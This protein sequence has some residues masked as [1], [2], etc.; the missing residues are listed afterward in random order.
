M[1]GSTISHYRI[2]EKI[3]EGGMGVVYKA[4]DTRLR[5]LVALKFL[6]E[7]LAGIPD[8]VA[9]F[10]REARHA[11]ALNHSHICTIY[12][13]AE[14]QG[15]HFIAMELLEGET[16]R[17]R[18]S[19]RTL[20][21]NE[22]IKMAIQ[23]ADAL[24]AAHD[25]G[26]I[27]QDLKPSNLFVTARGDV[28]ILD[29]GIAKWRPPASAE[30]ATLTRTSEPGTVA[31]TVRY[32]SPEQALG[33][34]AD[35]RSDLFSLG[36]VFYEMAT[37]RL[38]FNGAT[39]NEI[40][41]QIIHHQP[42]AIG[43]FNHDVPAELEAIIRKCLEKEPDRRYQAAR[44][45]LVDLRNLHRDRDTG[46]AGR[47]AKVT[48][49]AVLPLANMSGDPEQEYFTDGMTEAL[50]TDLA[51][52]GALR[53]IS[54]TSVMQ[55]KTVSKPLPEIGRELGV[56]A[57]IEGS[58]LRAGGRVR[59]TAQLIEVAT[60]EHLWADAYER[61]LTD[62]FALQSE[63]AQAI[64]G[65]VRVALTPDEQ[66]RMDHVPRVDPIAHELYLKG[67]YHYAKFTEEGLETAI[68]QFN[69][70]IAKDSRFAL[71]YV[72]LSDAYSGL[73][74]IYRP[75]QEV[76]PK[77]KTAATRALEL[78]DTLAEAH[79]A[80]A[81]VQL[82]F[83]WDWSGAEQSLTRAIELNPSLAEAHENYALTLAAIGRSEEAISRIR[84]AREL[85]PLNL[86]T[87]CWAAWIY[88]LARQYEAAIE[89]ARQAIALDPGFWVSY[90]C[91]GPALEEVGKHGEAIAALEK[92]RTI[93]D[94]TTVLE[95]LGG[96][97]AT[98]G[99]TDKAQQVLD[100]L[101]VRSESFY[102]CPFEVA[103]L[104]AGLGNEAKALEW[105]DKGVEHR[106]DCMPWMG[107]D[108]KL[109]ALSSLPG[110]RALRDKLGF[111]SR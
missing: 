62:I 85:A 56:G 44:E 36:A 108:P 35:P 79:T 37:N 82:Y 43:R 97:Y 14:V 25:K 16:L 27:H 24:D 50:I 81:V 32:M 77:A 19:N 8:A 103:T 23:L 90:T 91:L 92:A 55:Y 96:A 48:R 3:G 72:G 10:G 60:D 109:D 22:L 52:I 84:R 41:D 51:K 78:D 53:V 46:T 26:I 76:M 11:S 38:P 110:F 104:Y 59:I 29:F 80:L 70:A 61:E 13:V 33:K 15:R 69:Q 100:E 18:L 64:A 65:E 39:T 5:R 88:Y 107:T 93:D 49:L 1:I 28:K 102:I 47:A 54:R 67:R 94:N 111:P 20:G 17:E 34:A 21:A 63:I 87:M 89:E 98:A 31:G 74:S 4:E 42:E 30:S 73:R 6:P 101:V 83:D 2:V 58:V 95:M 99:Q 106:A 9:R 57:V 75:P 45:L 86:M 12:D 40:I 7:E 68:E 66:A 105:L 71:A